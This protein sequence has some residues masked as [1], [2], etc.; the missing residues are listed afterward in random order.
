MSERESVAS[1]VATGAGD[2]MLI[3]GKNAFALEL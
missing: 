2:S 3:E 1:G